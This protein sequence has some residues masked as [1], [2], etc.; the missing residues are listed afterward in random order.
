[1]EQ[2]KKL[3]QA[4]V[5]SNAGRP[6]TV[7]QL[8]RDFKEFEGYDIPYEKHGF[9]QLD[10]MLR[11][12]SDAI[13]LMGQGP[14]AQL[15]PVLTKNSKHI[16][17]MVEKQKNKNGKRKIQYSYYT[18]KKR[19]IDVDVQATKKAPEPVATVSKETRTNFKITIQQSAENTSQKQGTENV[20]PT[21]K[22]WDQQFYVAP[23]ST[24]YDSS[25][26]TR[27][28][29]AQ[30]SDEKTK[31][32]QSPTQKARHPVSNSTQDYPIKTS[33][34]Y[35]NYATRR[36]VGENNNR[37]NGTCYNNTGYCGGYGQNGFNTHGVCYTGSGTSSSSGRSSYTAPGNFMRKDSGFYS[38]ASGYYWNQNSG[39]TPYG[40][41]VSRI[42]NYST[43]AGDNSIDSLMRTYCTTLL[44]YFNESADPYENV[45]MTLR[46]FSQ[47]A[48]RGLAGTKTKYQLLASLTRTVRQVQQIQNLLIYSQF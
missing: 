25:K 5:I 32:K 6:L 11:S 35:G 23:N 37:H 40:V 38:D 15:L 9:R 42:P 7:S 29:F 19:K 12:M 14:S 44:N 43:N 4:M 48:S 27:S 31:Q 41:R 28:N 26:W 21:K 45:I 20:H 2:L 47:Q 13:Q 24:K 34:G 10:A 30:L 46:Q 33:T 39:Y 8:K 36:D 16:R 22:R 3:I 17:E 1:M 18:H